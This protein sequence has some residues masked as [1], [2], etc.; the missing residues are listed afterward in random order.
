MKPKPTK[1]HGIYEA[2]IENKKYIFTKSLDGKSYFG[3]MMINGF[4]EFS[5]KRSKL[6]AAIFKKISLV[7]LK[8]KNIV[9]YLGAAHG[10]TASYVSDI[11]G[12]EG[13]VFCIE[14]APRVARDL[15]LLCLQRKNMI[16]I[17]AD[18]NHPENYK[19]RIL[20]ADVIYQDI[21]QKNQVE[22]LFK[23]LELL[24]P[25]GYVMLAVKARSI[26]VTKKPKEIFSEVEKQLK[27][28]LK[29]I[30]SKL[31]EPFEKDHCFFV[32]QMK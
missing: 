15:Y 16:P 32:C 12:Q 13:A 18:A 5:P 11:I 7:P 19:H 23:N 20:Q 3:E 8:E 27:E 21:A 17:F 24:K 25:K 10:Y 4:R 14:F 9:L 22:I 31:L 29:V 1:Y 2:W 26:D 6:A 30:D 28:K